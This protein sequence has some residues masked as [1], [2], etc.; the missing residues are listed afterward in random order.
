MQ[1]VEYEQFLNSD[2]SGSSF[3]SLPNGHYDLKDS[4]SDE[5]YAVYCHMSEIDQCG[6]GGWT[7]VLKTDG[8]K[9]GDIGCQFISGVL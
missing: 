5:K 6:G 8:S 4:N 2:K 7:L 3:R 9:V 1:S